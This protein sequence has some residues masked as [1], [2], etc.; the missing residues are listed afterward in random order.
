MVKK[1]IAFASP[2]QIDKRLNIDPRHG[3]TDILKMNSSVVLIPIMADEDFTGYIA[4]TSEEGCAAIVQDKSTGQS[5]VHLSNKSSNP[6]LKHFITFYEQSNLDHQTQDS[7]YVNKTV[8]EKNAVFELRT[9][10]CSLND[11][12]KSTYPKE[13]SEIQDFDKVMDRLI[14]KASIGTVSG[15]YS[16]EITEHKLKKAAQLESLLRKVYNTETDNNVFFAVEELFS[17]KSDKHSKDLPTCIIIET[18]AIRMLPNDTMNKMDIEPLAMSFFQTSD[19]IMFAVGRQD[20]SSIKMYRPNEPIAELDNL[21]NDEHTFQIAEMM[22][23]GQCTITRP[24]LIQQEGEVMQ[25]D[26]EQEQAIYSLS[27]KFRVN[28]YAA[29]ID[30]II[31]DN[32]TFEHIK[33]TELATGLIAGKTAYEIVNDHYPTKDASNIVEYINELNEAIK[34][35][36]RTFAHLQEEAIE[37]MEK[38]YGFAA[39]KVTEIH[40]NNELNERKNVN[41]VMLE[42]MDEQNIKFFC[43]ESGLD[44]L[45]QIDGKLVNCMDGTITQPDQEFVFQ[46]V[47]LENTSNL[48][49]MMSWQFRGDFEIA[50][51][52]ESS[53]STPVVEK[54]IELKNDIIE[55]MNH[56]LEKLSE[57]I[58]DRYTGDVII[59]PPALAEFLDDMA[60][61][62][63]VK[64][65]QEYDGVEFVDLLNHYEDHCTTRPTPLLLAV[66]EDLSE[67]H[68]TRVYDL[69]TTLERALQMVEGVEPE[70]EP[71]TPK[72]KSRNKMK[73]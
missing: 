39:S 14:N 62:A 15:L 53:V 5:V 31:N 52:Y 61:H 50:T 26:N 11:F 32:S 51:N 42:I 24:L 16:G 22:Y 20:F 71:E 28:N 69:D 27:S 17:F 38:G 47:T 59:A 56:H 57:F 36:E 48:F 64:S 49:E 55:E 8:A 70:P 6:D 1:S 72:A 33:H 43:N 9:G 35:N 18:D 40:W 25:K 54:H 10:Y 63:F 37:L 65:N 58:A 19:N 29:F 4:I 41:N 21:N 23:V 12:F 73:I 66:M 13:T 68:D 2:Y 7:I 60:G 30:E 3:L 34:F 44:L 45:V 46:G 67:N